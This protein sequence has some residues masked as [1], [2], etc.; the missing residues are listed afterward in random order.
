M[1]NTKTLSVKRQLCWLAVIVAPILLAGWIISTYSDAASGKKG[2]QRKSTPRPVV[3][4]EAAVHV[5]PVELEAFGNLR[6]RRSITVTTATSGR[7]IGV[8]F[9]GGQQMT[10]GDV[11]LTLDSELERADVDEARARLQ[12]MDQ[13]LGRARQLKNRQAGSQQAVDSAQARRAAAAAELARSNRLF[14][15]R[16]LSAAFDGVVGLPQVAAGEFINSSMVITSL[17]DL[18]AMTV[19]FDLPESSYSEV[20]VN[21][22]VMVQA[23]ATEDKVF[24]GNVSEIDSRIDADT[25]TF[26]VRAVLPNEDWDLRVGMFV[27]VLLKL[28]EQTVLLIPEEALV[29]EGARNY[30]VSVAE[31]VAQRNEVTIGRR[32]SGMVEILSGIATGAMVVTL[33]HGRLKSGDEVTV[34]TPGETANLSPGVE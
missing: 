18:R 28:G 33:G 24:I 16:T 34:K 2:G 17:D 21:Q 32:T 19:D 20:A 22:L 13:E 15:Q 4:A 11:L 3:L 12:E 10:A 23:E 6:A 8:H 26:Q 25:G 9:N 7:V 27:Q 14:E 1:S 31:S 5:L 30:V 29:P